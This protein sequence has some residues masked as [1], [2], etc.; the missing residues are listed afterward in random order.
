MERREKVLRWMYENKYNELP[1]A[2]DDYLITILNGLGKVYD[3][4]F[5]KLL[6]S[7]GDV[8]KQLLA[9]ER[10]I[11]E[12]GFTLRKLIGITINVELNHKKDF[13]M[14]RVSSKRGDRVNNVS[15]NGGEYAVS[16]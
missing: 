5:D 7:D 3:D 10:R 2:I 12:I 6:D 13:R 16:V 4:N 9:N 8:R 15:T 14:M 1:D 11:N